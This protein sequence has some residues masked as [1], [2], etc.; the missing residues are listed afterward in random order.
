VLCPP[1]SRPFP[2]GTYP[3]EC[4]TGKAPGP[5]GRCLPVHDPSIDWRA[6]ASAVVSTTGKEAPAGSIESARS[7]GGAGLTG[8]LNLPAAMKT[9][10]A[11][12]TKATRTY[13]TPATLPEGALLF[14]VEFTADTSSPPKGATGVRCFMTTDEAVATSVNGEHSIG[15][16][17]GLGPIQTQWFQPPQLESCEDSLGPAPAVCCHPRDSRGG[18]GTHNL[19]CLLHACQMVGGPAV[20]VM[21]PKHFLCWL[22]WL[23]VC[24]QPLPQHPESHLPSS[25]TLLLPCCCTSPSL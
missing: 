13:G 1:L 20:T 8:S 5:N 12:A 7:A 3:R 25:D 9:A 14:K 11:A 24:C 6:D 18:G 4:P 23:C 17:P 10:S 19:A 16:A 21:P 2:V 15:A 22:L